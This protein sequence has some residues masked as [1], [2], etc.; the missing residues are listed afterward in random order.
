MRQGP[1]LQATQAWLQ[2]A[3]M[4]PEQVAAGEAAAWLE[5]CAALSAREQLGVY[6]RSYRLRLESCL[7]EQ[8]PVL[9]HALGDELFTDFAREYLRACP[10]E[11]YTLHDLGRRLADHLERER[12]D[13]KEGS[14]PEAWFDFMVDLA[15]FERQLFVLFD[16]EGH[17]AE[18]PAT[19]GTPDEQL[20]LGRG[21][22]LGEYRFAVASYH[23]DVRQGRE[24]RA[25]AP[26]RSWTALVR[27]GY[28]TQ[29]V[30]V[31][32]MQHQLLALLAAGARIGEALERAASAFGVSTAG[33]ERMWHEPGGTRERWIAAGFF[34]ERREG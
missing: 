30:P 27:K 20:A 29:I 7:R 34:V 21:V 22:M 14:E 17:E 19:P 25:P 11:S 12:P 33:A 10:P 23:H 4:S 24:P 18:A 15:R 6:Q 16:A 9:C 31:G 8:F 5:P 1:A 3:L 13:R 2:R 32:A 26:E 28:T